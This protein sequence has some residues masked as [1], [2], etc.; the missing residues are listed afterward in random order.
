MTAN[1]LDKTAWNEILAHYREWNKAEL[2]ARIREA[3]KKSGK[4][5]WREYLSIM[6]FGLLIKPQPSEHEQRKKAE[7]L[8][9]YYRKIQYFEEWRRRHG[10]SDQRGLA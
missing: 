10:Q 1:A 5:K 2:R 7:M 8:L 9:H 3:G 4:E 6:E